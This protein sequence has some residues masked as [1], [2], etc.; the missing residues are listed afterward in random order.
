MVGPYWESKPASPLACPRGRK[1]SPSLPASARAASSVS[2]IKVRASRKKRT[3]GS[4]RRIAATAKARTSSGESA[5][6]ASLPTPS[7]SPRKSSSA[8]DSRPASGTC[9]TRA[10]E[11]LFENSSQNSSTLRAPAEGI[12]LNS[13]LAQRAATAGHA[14][15]Q[16]S[17]MAPSMYLTSFHSPRSCFA[18]AQS[19]SFSLG[20]SHVRGETKTNV[21]SLRAASSTCSVRFS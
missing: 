18:C 17:N 7:L 19:D 12:S 10:G 16:S 2:T 5:A 1:I 13:Y 8:C 21:L 15:N 4:A 9:S 11:N 3:D 20:L 14:L 6:Y